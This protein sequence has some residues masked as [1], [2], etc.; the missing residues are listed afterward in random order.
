M[1]SSVQVQDIYASENID[2][3]M[4]KEQF[5]NS[6]LTDVKTENGLYQLTFMTD[7]MT[8]DVSEYIGETT[9]KA[10]NGLGKDI[11]ANT[12]IT[13]TTF[14]EKAA[15]N[16]VDVFNKSKQ[17]SRALDDYD[18]DKKHAWDATYGVKATTR[19]YYEEDT[20]STGQTSLLIYAVQGEIEVDDKNISVLYN[21]NNKLKVG[22]VDPLH[23]NQEKTYVISSAP[24]VK[25]MPTSWE[26]IDISQQFVYYGGAT[27]Y[28]PLQR[29][30][31]TWELTCENTIDS[32]FNVQ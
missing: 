15:E 28:V 5:V 13:I 8:D 21:S 3:E 31:T 9:K 19:V 16:L 17:L 18:Y 6:E 23:D 25:Y 2:S 26:P 22:C 29:G 10:K 11:K 4:I 7:Y 14:D 32:A 1:A 20:M 24:Y 12:V 27:W 30:G